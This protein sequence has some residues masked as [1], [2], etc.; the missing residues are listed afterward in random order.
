[1]KTLNLTLLI[2]ITIACTGTLASTS[3]VFDTDGFERITRYEEGPLVKSIIV[4]KFAHNLIVNLH[5]R[6]SG[7]Y[8][9][10]G[11][12]YDHTSGEPLAYADVSTLSK[13]SDIHQANVQIP[14]QYLTINKSLR[15][16]CSTVS[17]D[18]YVVFVNIPGAPI[19]DW[20]MSAEPLGKFIHRSNT[21]GY[22]S[23]YKV[24]S[25][26][27]VNNQNNTGYCRTLSNRGTELGLFHEK[28]NKGPFHSDVFTT[29]R[30]IDNSHSGQPIL[31][32]IIECENAVGKT[33]AVK[34]L[35]LTNPD[36]I[37]IVSE[38]LIVK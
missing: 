31:Y 32:Q 18:D 4:S 38:D 12:I 30:D 9:S 11:N 35:T 20:K 17:G 23:A 10:Y 29:N 19:I 33:L 21:Y 7:D 2:T 34:V 37:Y 6:N 27:N 1:M 3:K 13:Q 8:C 16:S 14:E 26:L 15:L 5:P 28:A 22:H 24:N 36:S 25:V